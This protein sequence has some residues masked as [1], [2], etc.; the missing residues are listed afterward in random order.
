MQRIRGRAA[1][2]GI[3]FGKIKFYRPDELVI[4]KHKVLN[5]ELE[6]Q[7]YHYAKELSKKDL[8]ELYE[9]EISKIGKDHAEIFFIHRMLIDDNGF[10]QKVVSAITE[11]SLNAEYAVHRAAAEIASGLGRAEDDYIRARTA[12]VLDIAGRLIRHIQN[13]PEQKMDFDKNTILCSYDLEPSETIRV[14]KTRV[15]AICTCYGSTTSHTSILARTMG[16]PS[17]TG[18]GKGLTEEY[19]GCDAIVDGF[20]GIL[21]I[22]PDNATKRRM[23]EKREEEGRK[24]ELLSRLR[25]R[26]NITLDGYEIDLYANIS[27]LTDLKYVEENDAGGIGL[28]RSEFLYLQNDDFPDEELQFYTYRRVL[29]KMKGKRVVVRTLDIGEDKNPDFIVG[30]QENP[31]MGM[32]SIRLFF[33][34][35][36]LFRTQMRALYRASMYGRLAILFPLIVDPEEIAAIKA[37][38][39]DVWEEMDSEGIEYSKD[40]ELGVM[41]ETPAAVM[42]SDE[43]AREMDFFNVGTNDL[44]QYVLAIDRN[45]VRLE[46]Y[47]RNHHLAVLRMIKAAADAIHRY[48]KWIGICGELAGNAELTEVFM[49]MGIDMLSVSPAKIL[50]MRRKIRSLTIGDRREKLVEA[51]ICPPADD[52]EAHGYYMGY[53]K[54]RR[55]G[56]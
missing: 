10:E 51:G 46:R 33:E 24:R 53:S 31:A 47:C 14:D 13:K 4:K 41:I 23:I 25:G 20:A 34:R 35:P 49:D 11:E 56:E 7:R 40:V 43:L 21:Y 30:E 52:E 8:D 15:K 39:C 37:M 9:R 27:G 1:S 50:P 28:L 48:G 29:E 18:L 22:E 32:R 12:D 26:R 5:P 54:N 38:I 36:D 2:G 6:L 44:E 17:L 45:D 16:I 19:D 55:Y 3:V 42:L